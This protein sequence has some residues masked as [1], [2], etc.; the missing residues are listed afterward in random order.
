MNQPP[1]QRRDARPYGLVV[2]W[3]LL[4]LALSLWAALGSAARPQH[5]LEK[6]VP[7][8]PPAAPFTDWL[9]RCLLLPWERWDVKYFVQIAAQGY[10]VDDGTA[11]FHP[12][13]P[14]LGKVVGVALGGNDLLGLIVVSSACGLAFLLLFE[15]L[16][17]LDL[18]AEAAQRAALYFLHLP[19]AFVLFA[20][21]TESLFLLC[22]AAALIA[23]R[24]ER[25][26][27]AGACGGLA[28]L[29]RQQGIFLLVPLAW[30]WWEAHRRR[31]REAAR[32]LR[33]LAGLALVPLAQAAWLVYRAAALN[34]VAYNRHEPR[35]LIYGLL[36]SRSSAQVVAEQNF[37][38]PWR[39]LALAL[40]HTDAATLIDLTL[41]GLFLFLFACGARRLWRMRKSYLLYSALILTV[42]FS[43][44]TGPARPYMGLP[45]HCLLAFPLVL[46]LAEWGARRPLHWFVL[47]AG[48][49]GLFALTLFYST[50]TV[51]VP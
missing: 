3:L 37:M 12:L 41:G 6:D 48:V 4:R 20:P 38:P 1:Q 15:R 17:R 33:G 35:S 36:I 26:L 27:I 47:V 8:W 46:P 31:P 16:V 40:D 23:A 2:V 14:L 44:N 45:R 21:Y 5:A 18:P 11:Q 10:R 49:L 29:T 32:D 24:H 9:A 7:L 43:L 42:S 19:V 28:V 51:W 30:E 25:R 50:H 34:D 22:C 39:A 13:Y